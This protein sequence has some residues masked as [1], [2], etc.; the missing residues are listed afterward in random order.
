MKEYKYVIECIW[1]SFSEF[2]DW[3]NNF[4]DAYYKNYTIENLIFK[5]LN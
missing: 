5:L 1:I 3:S 2:Y 4:Y